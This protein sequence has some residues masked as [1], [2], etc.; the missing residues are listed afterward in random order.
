MEESIKKII[1]AL[2]EAVEKLGDRPTGD[3][4][5]MD[6][7][8][9]FSK[10][11]Q[12]ERAEQDKTRAEAIVKEQEKA[13]KK[14]ETE[15]GRSILKQVLPVSIIGFDNGALKALKEIIPDPAKKT[16]EQNDKKK[17]DSGFGMS[18]LKGLAYTAFAAIVGPVMVLF[19]FFE[20]I[21]KQKWFI[22]L[23]NFVKGKFWEPLKRFFKPVGDFFSKIKNSKF[24]KSIST[25]LDDMWKSIKDFGSKIKNSKF[26]K[27]ILTKLDDMWKGIKDFGGKIKK[28]F[29]PLTKLFSSIGKIFGSGEGGGVFTRIANFFSPAKN[30]VIKN[31]MK[32]TKGIGKVLGKIFLP[33]TILMEAFNFI[34]GFMKGYEEGGVISGLEQG[35]TDVFNS[36][37]G[38]P[39]DMLKSGVSWILGAFGFEEAE[40]ALDA[41]SFQKLFDKMFKNIFKYVKNI[42]GNLTGIWDSITDG[43][44]T[45]ALSG[46]TKIVTNVLAMPLDLL[47]DAVSWLLSVFGFDGASETLDSFSFSE[48]YE[49]MV[50]GIFN[51]FKA[52]IDWVVLLFTEPKKAFK[53]IGDWFNKLFEDPLGTIKEM[54]PQWMIDFGGWVYTN[55][56][57]PIADFF[58]ITA[59]NPEEA[60][61]AFIDL[62]PDWMSGF[63]PWIYDNMIDPIVNFVDNMFKG[64]PDKAFK[65]L[66]PAWLV[67][68]VKSVVK[69]IY[70]NTIGVPVTVIKKLFEGDIGGAFQALVPPWIRDV[71]TWLYN[72]TIGKIMEFFTNVEKDGPG[73]KQKFLNMLPSWMT[74]FGSWLW[75]SAI[76]PIADFF[77]K[78]FQGDAV[79]AFSTFLPEWLAKGIV[80]IATWFYDN[81]IGIPINFVSKLFEGDVGGAF[82]ALIPPWMK[83]I[84][85]FF[86]DNLIKP[87]VDIFDGLMN[88][89]FKHIVKDKI[90]SIPVVGEKIYNHLFGEGDAMAAAQNKEAE[91]QAANLAKAG[92]G[93]DAATMVAEARLKARDDRGGDNLA[94]GAEDYEDRLESMIA[95]GKQL[96]DS[97]FKAILKGMESGGYGFHST[98]LAQEVFAQT[99]GAFDASNK[100]HQDILKKQLAKVKDSSE[101]SWTSDQMHDEYDESMRLLG[102]ASAKADYDI[103]LH[104]DTVNATVAALKKT[105]GLKLGNEH[106]RFFDKTPITGT[107]VAELQKMFSDK[108]DDNKIIVDALKKLG[109]T[110]ENLEKSSRFQSNAGTAQDF[111]WR[112]G[113]EP[114]RFSK[115]DI[116]MGLHQDVKPPATS[117]D[118]SSADRMVESSEQLVERVD[119]MVQLMHEHSEIHGKILEV[120]QESGLMDKQGNTVVNNGGNST[121]INNNTVDSDIMGFRDKV[122]GRL[123][124]VPTK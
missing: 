9:A 2:T 32:F 109:I 99:G 76:K 54:L 39:L 55:A 89:D 52:G 14:A 59:A 103:G 124:H 51:F 18:L 21:Q 57:K 35:V 43:D 98:K 96:A 4:A 53:K 65:S 29:A 116:V 6:P 91:K 23:K 80:G 20:E 110:P 30:P 61:S 15:K 49:Q 68:G 90:K 8:D 95:D 74:G 22:K 38:W 72:N 1:A 60:K 73:M 47:K 7:K 93:A 105:G 28:F 45:G 78:L 119:K 107:M 40:K 11:A 50:D 120:L 41:F 16:K 63:G 108:S 13:R 34:T 122:V 100:K 79:E 114:M 56:I 118:T 85:N 121:V 70:D 46:V 117:Q 87:I 92:M 104:N 25:K 101:N 48:I 24:I 12:Q 71:G 19:G 77:N 31:I 58:S 86:Y 111:I 5:S 84:G 94:D 69:F 106:L 82:S 66:L 112:P 97:H 83:D 42:F 102:L 17:D 36:L 67:D 64:D 26:I 44:I 113:Q 3:G 33:V 123:K 115:G 27:S 62:L 37:I 75:D 81:T 10:S 88:I